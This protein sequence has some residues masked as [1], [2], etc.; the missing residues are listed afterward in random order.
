MSRTLPVTLGFLL[1]LTSR[2]QQTPPSSPKSGAVEGRVVDAGSGEPIRKAIVV[3][4]KGQE[5]GVGAYTDGNGSFRFDK[6][7]AGA[8][9]VSAVREGFVTEPQGER[10]L[11]TVKPEA[12]ESDIVVKL[13]PTGAISGRVLDADGDPVLGATVQ[14][15]PARKGTPSPSGSAG[16]NDRGE[17]RVFHVRPGKYRIAAFG[18]TTLDQVRRET[19]GT[20]GPVKVAGT[21]D[22]AYTTTYYPGTPDSRQATIVDVGAGSDLQGFDVQLVRYRAVHVR[23]RLVE[24]AGVRAEL[25]VNV[26]LQ[27]RGSL[28]GSRIALVRDP[29]G[30]FEIDGVLP[31]KYVLMASAGLNS[32][33][34][35]S[36]RETLEVGSSDVEGIQLTLAPSQK[37]TGRVV[38]PE[39]RNM[40]Q[41][42]F[43]SLE[44]RERD[45]HF[46]GAQVSADGT[47]DVGVVPPGS[48]DVVVATTGRGG[49]LYVS[50]IRAGDEDVLSKG[51]HIGG[52]SPAPIEI[53]Y[54]AG[55]ATI[56]CTVRGSKGEPVPGAEVQLL[57]DVPRRNQ[58]ALYS[59]CR[60]DATGACSMLGAAPGEYHAFAIATIDTSDP[61]AL[62]DIEK[63]GKSVMVSTGERQELQLE[64][65]P[66]EP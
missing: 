19:A 31:G 65:I 41:G 45:Q 15:L 51:L 46:R 16:T 10:L 49:D 6:V 9:S 23:G 8:Y 22:E 18:G 12:T 50:A 42:L 24:P 34:E 44:S 56:D 63:Y 27:P 28:S 14:V 2:G 53:V 30:K 57:P 33:E 11:V 13:V 5:D 54:Q 60:T 7:E 48:Y 37:I 43:V 21:I 35:V 58:R 29:T 26:M 20:G 3:L 47:F 61:D 62:K 4:R 17:Y 39:G 59:G 38:L 25:F 66:Q 36:A 55:G 64:L 52:A 40:P 1:C 32:Q